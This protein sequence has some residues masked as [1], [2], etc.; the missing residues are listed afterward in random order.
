MGRLP[1]RKRE[2]DQSLD[3]G[4]GRPNDDSASLWRGSLD[5]ET[6]MTDF[7]PFNADTA[8]DQALS[9][10]KHRICTICEAASSL[11]KSFEIRTGGRM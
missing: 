2:L 4:G 9:S 6:F 1:G 3:V 5:L 11:A 7:L 8:S 10:I